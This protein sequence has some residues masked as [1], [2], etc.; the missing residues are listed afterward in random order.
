MIICAQ[1]KKNQVNIDFSNSSSTVNTIVPVHCTAFGNES[2]FNLI[3]QCKLEYVRTYLP[4][5]ESYTGMK[6]GI[7]KHSGIHEGHA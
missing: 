7:V 6:G 3:S 1:P 5:F 2:L 4:A